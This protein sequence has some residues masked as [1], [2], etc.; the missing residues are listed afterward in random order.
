[1]EGVNPAMTDNARQNELISAISNLE[2]ARAISLVEELLSRNYDPVELVNY[3]QTGMRQVG[4]NYSRHQYSLSGLIM[5]GEIFREIMDLINPV[6]EN[7]PSKSTI[8]TI[9]LGTVSGDIHDLG[10]N[11]VSILF[12]CNGYTVFD[13]GVDVPASEFVKQSKILKPDIIGLSG[14]ITNALNSMHETISLL[15]K[16]QQCMPIIIGGSQLSEE[17][18]H[19]T[20]SDFWVNDA[21]DG[22]A[23]CNSILT[24]CKKLS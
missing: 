10:K 19:Y 24:G 22:L 18:R 23:I 11:I 13:L 5:G 16:E 7:K 17:A 21:T 20:C 4:E 14:L 8:G 6:I 2:E 9:L 15:R 1:M 12:K 3:C